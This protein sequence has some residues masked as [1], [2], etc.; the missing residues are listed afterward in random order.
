ML[1]IKNLTAKMLK[2]SIA[3]VFVKFKRERRSFLD[4]ALWKD[5][6]VGLEPDIFIEEHVRVGP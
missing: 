1:F 5:S 3:Y 4:W 2:P 6:E